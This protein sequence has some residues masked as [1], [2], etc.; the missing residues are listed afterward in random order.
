[1]GVVEL[2]APYENVNQM[3]PRWTPDHRQHQF[4]GLNCASSALRNRFECDNVMSCSIALDC[5]HSQQWPG[6]IDSTRLLR[7]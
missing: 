5:K 4:Y 6:Q 7:V 3:E 2:A 1:M